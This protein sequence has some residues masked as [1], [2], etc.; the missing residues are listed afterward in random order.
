MAIALRYKD[1]ERLA[2]TV[3]RHLEI[4]ISALSGINSHLSS[5]V[6]CQK[7]LVL[8][9]S[10]VISQWER[11][12]AGSHIPCGRFHRSQGWEL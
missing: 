6:A 5:R 4:F 12:A 8:F 7:W 9:L 3:K 11:P 1:I 2:W 10:G